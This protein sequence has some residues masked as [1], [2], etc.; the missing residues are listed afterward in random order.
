MFDFLKKKDWQKYVDKE[1]MIKVG[2][3][4]CVIL[5]LF[6]SIQSVR[7]ASIVAR[8][9]Q[10]NAGLVDEV[11][12]FRKDIKSFGNDINEMRSFLLLPTKD[13]SFVTE[14]EQSTDEDQ[15]A[16]SD[17]EVALYKY[18]ESFVYQIKADENAKATRAKMDALQKDEGL[19]GS[20]KELGLVMDKP[21]DDEQGI[22]F[23]ILADKEVTFTVRG[24][25]KTGELK[26]SDISETK[27]LQ[28]TDE[29][30][31]A[32]EIIE[33]AKANTGMI[34]NAKK[35]FEANRLAVSNLMGN[36]EVLNLLVQQ[37]LR[38]PETPV[39][40][41]DTISYPITNREEAV[42]LTVSVRLKDGAIM[43]NDEVM[44]DLQT[45]KTSL[46]DRVT[47]IDGSTAEEKRVQDRKAELEA[48]LKDEAFE[49]LLKV[50][51]L[52]VT[53]EPREEYNK[54]LY[55]VTDPE[56]KVKFSFVIELSSGLIKILKDNQETDILSAVGENAKKK[57]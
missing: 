20:L 55:D 21:K 45:L 19:I 8:V 34:A 52:K 26:I 46:L 47:K 28:G 17:T 2:V 42:M 13:Y 44:K 12:G 39:K 22:T 35:I 7:F 36:E 27:T 5:L 23:E 43:L 50:G 4:V 57:L 53:M 37:D 54:L 16:S 49:A 40:N 31:L 29:K 9:D 32:Q 3:P 51:G 56:G 41:S 14:D 38:L 25:L 15:Q 11:G 30:L 1:T 33:F 10:Y 48:V 24:D 18:M 6:S